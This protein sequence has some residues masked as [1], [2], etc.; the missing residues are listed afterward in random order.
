MNSIGILLTDHQSINESI[1]LK[2]VNK[3]KNSRLKLIFFIGDKKKFPKLFNKVSKLKKCQFIHVE[4]RTKSFDYLNNILN[5]ALK[6]FKLNKIKYIINMPIDKK[7]FLINKYPGF[8]EMFSQKIDN[9]KNENMLLFSQNFSVC[10]VTT[11][12][13]LNEVNAKINYKIVNQALKNIDNFYKKTLK[14]K[15]KLSILGMNPHASKDFAKKNK[16]NQILKKI[17][18]N[19]KKK[20]VDI[21]G[22][23]SADT[24]FKNYKNKVYIGM[25]HDQVLIPFKLI[26]K[27][28]GINITIGKKYI[29]LSPDH[30]TGV[31]IFKK[32]KKINTLS[33]RKC[34]EFCEKY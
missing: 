32:N 18:K 12:I 24:A 23:L 10:P 6:L 21:D 31:D 17:V 19:L 14:K 26:N 7:K 25:Y 33:F 5:H 4:N 34:I 15:I 30:G 2:S 1:I 11:H 27:F 3:I 20:K 22:P 9:K 29:R 28:N 16:D 8:T 13:P